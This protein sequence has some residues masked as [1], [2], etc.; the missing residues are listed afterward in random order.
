MQKHV[1]IDDGTDTPRRVTVEPGLS[2]SGLVEI[3]PLDGSIEAGDLVVVGY[4]PAE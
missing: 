4:A 3:T 2:T 1:E